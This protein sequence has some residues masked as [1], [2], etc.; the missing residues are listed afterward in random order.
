MLTVVAM[1]STNGTDL[2]P[3][4]QAIENGRLRARIA[5]IISD[6]PDAGILTKAR[7]NG[8]PW[9][10]ADPKGKKREEFDRELL[11]I[12]RPLHPQVIV[13]IGYM[14]ILS[15]V[16]IAEFR[17]KIINVHPSLL[18][19]FAGGM[20]L[21]VH[22]AVI[23]SGRSHSGCTIHIVDESVDGG[24]ILCQKQVVIAPGE[25]AMA[26]KQKIQEKEG[27]AFVEVLQK[28]SRSP[29]RIENKILKGWE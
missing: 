18:P 1:G 20:D 15:S 2:L 3:I 6:K 27:E 19:D 28:W 13:L 23:E 11:G 22:K 25:T 9:A 17:N 14:R 21:A 16:F 8:I 4:L 10:F 26:L 29:P 5:M 24:T 7:Q 12:I